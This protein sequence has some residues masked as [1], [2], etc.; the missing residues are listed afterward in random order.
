MAELTDWEEWKAGNFSSSV[1][2]R[3]VAGGTV[4]AG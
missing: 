1:V 2:A 3:M 4:G